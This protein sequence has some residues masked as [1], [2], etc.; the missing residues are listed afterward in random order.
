M[1]ARTRSPAKVVATARLKNRIIWR[2]KYREGTCGNRPS[3]A[4]E[5]FARSLKSSRRIKYALEV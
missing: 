3:T 4:S 2:E 1:A 5:I